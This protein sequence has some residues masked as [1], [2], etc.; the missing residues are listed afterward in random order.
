MPIVRITFLTT[1]IIT[2]KPSNYLLTTNLLILRP[3]INYTC[4]YAISFLQ[5]SSILAKIPI[6]WLFQN[7]F[8]FYLR[9]QDMT[10]DFLNTLPNISIHALCYGSIYLSSFKPT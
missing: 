7:S 5:N 9:A 6:P 3:L 8:N 10:L 2:N 1:I 4:P